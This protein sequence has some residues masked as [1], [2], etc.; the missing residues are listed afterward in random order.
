MG[1]V[2]ADDRDLEK[3]VEESLRAGQQP[4]EI[5]EVL[6]DAGWSDAKI[7]KAQTSYIMSSWNIPVPVKKS[8]LAARDFA[9]YASLFLTLYISV[10]YLNALIFDILNIAYPQVNQY[11]D[12]ESALRVSLSSVIIFTPVYLYLARLSERRKREDPTCRMS[13]QSTMVDLFD[14]SR[15]GSDGAHRARRTYGGFFER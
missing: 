1:N 3:F 9:F 11:S 13:R 4:N 2:V 7:H 6:R 8:S 14:N 15:W 12:P 5:T 10:Y